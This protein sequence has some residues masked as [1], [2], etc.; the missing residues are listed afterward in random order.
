MSECY[1]KVGWLMH[2]TKTREIIGVVNYL[3]TS[4]GIYVLTITDLYGRIENVYIPADAE[5][6]HWEFCNH[7]YPEYAREIGHIC[8]AVHPYNFGE[9]SIIKTETGEPYSEKE[10]HNTILVDKAIELMNNTTGHW[11]CENTYKLVLIPVYMVEHY[12][13]ISTS[14][15]AE[16]IQMLEDKYKLDEIAKLRKGFKNEL[17]QLPEID[18]IMR[19]KFTMLE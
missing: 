11:K 17:Y 6:I 13:I 19:M 4:I 16:S 2:Y 18:A 7:R 10:R 15:N 12:R 9:F 8:L 3:E 1:D 14:E 5:G